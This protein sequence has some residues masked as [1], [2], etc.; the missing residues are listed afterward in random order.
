VKTVRLNEMRAVT[1][2][3]RAANGTHL[4]AA[5]VSAASDHEGALHAPGRAP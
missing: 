2:G 5:L 1:H 4:D 3:R